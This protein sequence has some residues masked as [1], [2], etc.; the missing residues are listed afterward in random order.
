LNY[1]GIGLCF[2]DLLTEEAPKSVHLLSQQVSESDLI[3]GDSPY[4]YNCAKTT[5]AFFASI[6]IGNSNQL[7]KLSQSS[8]IYSS[9]YF[10][11][12]IEFLSF[13]SL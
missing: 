11:S 10:M 12:P 7:Y 2:Q 1:N 3:I 4:D 6:T 9:I 5:K 8:S 13:V